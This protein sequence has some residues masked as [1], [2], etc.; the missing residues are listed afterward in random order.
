MEEKTVNITISRKAAIE[1]Y[2]VIGRLI[3]AYNYA[4]ANTD[5]ERDY[6][7]LFES[8]R[9]FDSEARAMTELCKKLIV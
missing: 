5:S 4:K 3:D 8:P 2:D 7:D 6:I 1:L 9:I